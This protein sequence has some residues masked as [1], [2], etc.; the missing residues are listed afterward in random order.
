VVSK[1]LNKKKITDTANME[2]KMK[3]NLAS[4]PIQNEPAILPISRKE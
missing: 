3:Y 1:I 4:E 2:N